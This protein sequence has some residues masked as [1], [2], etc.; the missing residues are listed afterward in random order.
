[1]CCGARPSLAGERRWTTAAEGHP[2][3][4]RL[5]LAG[6]GRVGGWWRS[7]EMG[8]SAMS[9]QASRGAQGL[10]RRAGEE[11]GWLLQL[12][13]RRWISLGLGFGGDLG[14]LVRI[15]DLVIGIRLD[16]GLSLGMG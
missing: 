13:R 1:M 8:S 10:P 5:L 14:G 2:V 4:L 3:L 6:G 7:G 12:G 11:M 9:L 16:N 15:C